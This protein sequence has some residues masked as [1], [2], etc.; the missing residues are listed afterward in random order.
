VLC[1]VL[2]V[3]MCCVLC[4]VIDTGIDTMLQSYEQ[5]SNFRIG[6]NQEPFKSICTQFLSLLPLTIKTY[7]DRHFTIDLI[8]NQQLRVYEALCNLFSPKTFADSEK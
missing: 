8:L 1:V 2:R 5:I 4:Y 6:Y 3:V 7:Q